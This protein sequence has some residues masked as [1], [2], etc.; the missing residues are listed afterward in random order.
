MPA[1][2]VGIGGWTNL[3]QGNYA[4]PSSGE[5]ILLSCCIDLLSLSSFEGQYLVILSLGSMTSE[6]LD[7]L[8]FGNIICR[9]FKA[10]VAQFEAGS[11]N[12]WLAKF[13]RSTFCFVDL[14]CS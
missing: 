1:S 10:F 6:L 13:R 4:S 7:I 8:Y 3:L 14:S 2:F 12:L 5:A 11:Y 9:V